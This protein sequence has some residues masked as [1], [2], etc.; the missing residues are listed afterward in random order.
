M[1][2]LCRRPARCGVSA[3]TTCGGRLAF[4][5]PLRPLSTNTRAMAI[6]KM[7]KGG[8]LHR[9]HQKRKMRGRGVLALTYLRPLLDLDPHRRCR[10]ILHS[11]D[12]DDMRRILN[13][14]FLFSIPF[15]LLQSSI[16]YAYVLFISAVP[17]RPSTQSTQLT[18]CGMEVW[19]SSST[20]W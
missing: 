16:F 5:S 20:R 18:P 10:I 2:T 13:R 19:N 6:A 14:E 1:P 7:L 15:F 3:T 17:K 8:Q 12:G 11:K 9:G 4:R